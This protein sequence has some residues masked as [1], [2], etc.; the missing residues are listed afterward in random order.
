MSLEANHCPCKDAIS[1]LVASFH[2]HQWHWASVAFPV[3]AGRT[4]NPFN[5]ELSRI[6]K[7]KKAN[8]L[9]VDGK[10]GIKRS[11]W[12]R[13]WKNDLPLYAL[14]KSLLPASIDSSQLANWY[15]ANAHSSSF[16]VL[17]F[18]RSFSI[19]FASPLSLSLSLSTLL[20]N[21]SFRMWDSLN[22]Q[23]VCVCEGAFFIT[24]LP[25]EEKKNDCSVSGENRLHVYKEIDRSCDEAAAAAAAAA[26]V[27]GKR[28]DSSCCDCCFC[29]PSI[30]M[31]SKARGIEEEVGRKK[32]DGE[33]EV[34]RSW[35]LLKKDK[36]LFSSQLGR[37]I[38]TP[39]LSMAT[40]KPITI[41]WPPTRDEAAAV[42]QAT[43]L[44]AR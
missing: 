44:Q 10:R 7:R 20:F 19:S 15:N 14:I 27:A 1:L 24:T 41:T 21:S 16:W 37:L 39:A 3:E 11:T 43:T 36:W 5:R 34:R 38:F 35:W 28:S 6:K 13:R 26:V 40:D 4:K 9:K 32:E 31:K 25:G 30:T 8:T 18:T 23:R 2:S 17:L 42:A 12:E 33:G 29:K 22:S